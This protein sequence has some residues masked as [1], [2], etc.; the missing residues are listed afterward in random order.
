MTAAVPG[1]VVAVLPGVYAENVVLK[2]FVRLLSAAT[3]STDSTVFST[4]TGDALS[5]VIR[6]PFGGTNDVTVSATGLESFNGLSAEI[7]GFTIA[8][9]LLGDPANGS[10]DPN[11]NG[12][13]VQNSDLMIDK[14]YVVDAGIGI[15]VITSGSAALTPIIENDAVIG[16][17]TGILIVDGGSTAAT[18]APVT[19]TNNDF[20]FNTTGLI[21]FNSATTPLQATI[22]SNIFW[23]NHDQSLARNGFA[24]FSTNPNKV[25]LRNNLFSGNGASE[26]SQANATNNLGNGF[27]PALLGPT[28]AD[29]LAN[30]GNFTGNP[31]FVFPIDPRPG[32]DGPATFFLDADFQLTAASAAIDNAWEATAIPTDLLGNSQVNEGFGF[33]LP[34]YGPRDVGA[35]EFNGIGGDPVGGAFRVVTTSLAPVTGAQG[36][37]GASLVVGSSPS[38]IT[39]TFSN[40]VNPQDISATDLVLSGSAVNSAS[41]VHAASLTW[42]DQHTVEFN[43][44]GNLQLPGTLNV[45]IATG[46]IKS[47]TGSANVGY[48]DRVALAIGTPAK[49]SNPTPPLPVVQVVPPAAPPQP[50]APLVTPPPAL[51]PQGPL[52]AK[53]KPKVVHH[54]VKKHHPVKVH[55][56]VKAHQPVKLH[57]GA[58]PSPKPKKPKK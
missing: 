12:I 36:A 6:A 30:L 20:A 13:L 55:H 15:Q 44:A 38:A 45:G 43:L 49:P 34:G 41:P 28:A 1:D 29:A 18:T 35:F 56:P 53:K 21:L 17:T 46:T 7:A 10:I 37:N 25:S 4:S 22:D 54:P 40:N 19:V 52:H 32:S 9:P 31:A 8:S 58:G 39:V 2:Q 3:S 47:T 16:N 33:Q 50:A 27:S 57:R 42:I 11:S 23:E 51:A 48:S 5:T 14:D 24:I 26:T